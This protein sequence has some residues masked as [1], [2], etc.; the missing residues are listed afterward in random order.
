MQ[1]ERLRVLH[2]D[3]HSDYVN[4]PASELEGIDDRLAV[5]V[6][7]TVEDAL[8][9]LPEEDVDCIVTE[10]HLG[11]RAEQ[12]VERLRRV[13][14][15]I[16]IVLFTEADL[17][18]VESALSDG[19]T[20]YVPK[21]RASNERTY[22]LLAERIERL[23]DAQRTA[24]TD[25]SLSVATERVTD[26]LAVPTCVLVADEP[27]SV[28]DAFAERFDLD[29]ETITFDQ[30]AGLAGRDAEGLATFLRAPDSDTFSFET[31]DGAQT[32]VH[33]TVDE[34]TATV[35][36]L[37]V[38]SDGAP[39]IEATMLD[40]LLREVPH[41][42]YF[43]DEQ[44][45]HVRASDTL[46]RMNADGYIESPEGKVHYTA[47]DILGKTDFDLYPLE[48]AV[49]AV[50]DDQRVMETEEP[51][52]R[53]DKHHVT[54]GGSDI[55]LS[56]TKAPWYDDE[57][58][59]RGVVG[60][61]IDVTDETH[62]TDAAARQTAHLDDIEQAVRTAIVD[63]V[64]RVRQELD[65]GTERD[66]ADRLADARRSVETVER[67][68]RA[69]RRLARDSQPPTELET[70][71]VGGVAEE[72][73]QA[74][75]P[76]QATLSVELDEVTVAD[77]GRLKDLYEALFENALNHAGPAV[78]VRIGSHNDGFFVE[79]DGPGVDPAE[80]ERVLDVGYSSVGR[81]AGLGLPL[82]AHVADS[83]GWV[84][85]VCEGTD[86]GFRV[87]FS[88]LAGTA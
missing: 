59:V 75:D 66:D 80:T 42:I 65:V 37:W 62:D 78:T 87:E 49:P 18:T 72:T 50:E 54:P 39:A 41:A 23:V 45:R 19:P 9:T 24:E 74:L 8:A 84:T 2:V 48:H 76:E 26:D 64:E 16:P 36:T 79:D 43:K 29:P 63:P 15:E 3:D 7:D 32:R 11:E 61:S 67:A 44:S 68:A 53:K 22:Q 13:D 52:V 38:T 28:N 35:A 57:G 47:E 25:P 4:M 51:I 77:R 69:V 6:V 34:A 82:V 60:I 46:P 12:P 10:Y 86:G 27:V 30:I 17:A 71:D 20:E 55:H 70:V 14:A 56:T 73:W 81:A 83:F 1:R 40:S 85:T 31:D 21:D 88:G 5:D 33:A 58:Q